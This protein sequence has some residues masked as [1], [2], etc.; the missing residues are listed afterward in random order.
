MAHVH[1]LFW[2]FLW[3]AFREQLD[4]NILAFNITATISALESLRDSLNSVGESTLANNTQ[5]VI[6]DLVNIR[7]VQLPNI[8]SDVV[9]GWNAGNISF[10]TTALVT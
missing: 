5:L 1:N 6:D 8:Q 9:S 7:D 3:T 10:F 4:A 2:N